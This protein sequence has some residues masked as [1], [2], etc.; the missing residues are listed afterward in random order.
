MPNYK[1]D[2]TYSSIF[3]VLGVILGLL[4]LYIIRDIIALVIVS[5]FLAAAI[6]PWVNWFHKHNIPR[7]LAVLIIYLIVFAGVSF[8]FFLIIPPLAQQISMLANSFP[9]YFQK[10][11][12]GV[13]EIEKFSRDASQAVNTENLVSYVQG[14]LGNAAKGVFSVISSFFGSMV[15]LVAT[16]VLT[17]YMVLNEELLVRSAKLITPAKHRKYVGDFIKRS[18]KKLGDWLRGQLFL[19][20]AIAVF[21]YIGL[22]ILGIKFALVLAL[23]AGLLEL[24]P[25]AGPILSAIPAIILALNISP[26]KAVLVIVLYF[27]IQQAENHI[28]VPKVMEKAVGLNPIITIIAILIGAKLFGIMGAILAVPVA[29]LVN[30]FLEDFKD[31]EEAVHSK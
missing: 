1:L 22:L 23:I 7:A 19:M 30:M 29:T 13:E 4:F 11:I 8:I 3:R 2:I 26:I 12:L 17:F 18:Q 20:L 14:V 9:Q 21:T 16:L 25:Y 24:I 6:M 15:F 5:L 10:L 27:I 31:H 28:L